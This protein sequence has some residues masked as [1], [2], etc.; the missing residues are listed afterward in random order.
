MTRAR[1]P[2]ADGAAR[3]HARSASS[4]CGPRRSSVRARGIRRVPSGTPAEVIDQRH[5]PPQKTPLLCLSVTIIPAHLRSPFATMRTSIIEERS[6]CS[7]AELPAFVVR[8][9]SVA[10]KER[11]VVGSRD[12]PSFASF[13]LATSATASRLHVFPWRS[14]RAN[15]PRVVFGNSCP[16]TDRDLARRA[17]RG[18]RLGRPLLRGAATGPWHARRREEESGQCTLDHRTHS[19]PSE[20]ERSHA[21]SQA[22]TTTTST[23]GSMAYVCADPTQR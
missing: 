13:A 7:P 3:R 2:P 22:S 12:E 16:H 5:G 23:I 10:P 17:A 18:Y 1:R 9:T 21:D 11:R 15:T 8:R 6:N 4:F 14:V 20:E 19:P